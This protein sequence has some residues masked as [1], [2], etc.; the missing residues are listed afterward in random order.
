MRYWPGR[1]FNDSRNSLMR[2]ALLWL[3]ERQQIFN[4][5]KRNGLARQ[6]ASRFVAGE[7]IETAIEAV[8]HGRPEGH[9]RVARPA[10]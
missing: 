8:A 2:K 7:T 6:F 1:D 9:H 5:V 4:F 3:S 10:G